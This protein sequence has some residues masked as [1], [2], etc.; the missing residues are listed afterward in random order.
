[1]FAAGKEKEQNKSK[2]FSNPDSTAGQDGLR[3]TTKI[4]GA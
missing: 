1:V 2:V 3:D 4:F